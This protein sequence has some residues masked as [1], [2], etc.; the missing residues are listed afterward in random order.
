MTTLSTETDPQ[1]YPNKTGEE[2]NEAEIAHPIG[3]GILGRYPIISVVSFA[4]LGIFLGIGLAAWTPDDDDAEK[5]EVLI[6]WIGLVGDLFIRC[7]SKCVLL[8]S[9]TL[10]RVCLS[11]IRYLT[12][13]SIFESN[14]IEAVILPLVFINVTIAVVDMMSVGRAG[15]VGK[16]TVLLYITTTVTASVV[17]VL[18]TI[19][20]K[21]LFSQGSFE[22][23]GPATVMLGCNMEDTYITE[24]EDGNISCTADMG[25]SSQFFINDISKSFVKASSGPASSYTLSDT[26]YDGVFI[27]LITDNIFQSFVGG[28]YE[29]YC[30]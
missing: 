7:L 10:F 14:R 29:N 2:E 9:V 28:S 30:N 8:Y 27:K 22:E 16:K 5:K 12:K 3:C 13:T 17:G 25:E 24:S 11:M 23:S 19:A 26:V 21:G 6:K 15:S 18:C 1:A 4:A 20:C